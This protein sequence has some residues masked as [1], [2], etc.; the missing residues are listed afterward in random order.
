[1]HTIRE[2]ARLATMLAGLIAPRLRLGF[3]S[4][5]SRLYLDYASPTPHLRL[6]YALAS[7]F[8]EHYRSSRSN[9]HCA[10]RHVI[11]YCITSVRRLTAFGISRDSS[12]L[13]VTWS[14]PDSWRST[15]VVAILPHFL[16]RLVDARSHF[17][18][19][20]VYLRILSR[21]FSINRTAIWHHSARE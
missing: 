13:L 7:I 17:V 5:M 19:A 11:Y 8:C 3:V 14:H 20:L 9:P 2:I 15:A 6:D 12:A 16:P 4:A 10:P 21:S 1:M 18:I